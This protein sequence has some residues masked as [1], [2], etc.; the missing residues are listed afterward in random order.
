MSFLNLI[1]LFLLSILC[2]NSVV[3]VLR[4]RLVVLYI[5]TFFLS[6]VDVRTGCT[7]MC[8]HEHVFFLIDM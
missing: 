7:C 8:I 2:T 5:L 3:H 6:F 4:N 1:D